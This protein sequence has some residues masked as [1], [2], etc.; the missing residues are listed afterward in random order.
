MGSSE[1]FAGSAVIGLPFHSGH[2]LALRWF[3]ASSLGHGYT[4]I[5]HR[6]PGRKWTF[7]SVAP[8]QSCSR[9]FGSEI[10]ENVHAHIRIECFFSLIVFGMVVL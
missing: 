2:V 7:Y 1:R 10:E 6:D 3:P 5:W 9:Y 8:E 4:S